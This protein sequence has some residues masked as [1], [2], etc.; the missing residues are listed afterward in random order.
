MTT[1]E[2]GCFCGQVRYPIT[3]APKASVICHCALCRRAAATPAMPWITCDAEA[4]ALTR[5]EPRTYRSSPPVTRG[6]CGACGTPLTYANDSRPGEI[7]VTTVSL[8][9]S[10][11]FAPTCH[12]RLVEALGWVKFGDGLPAYQGWKSEG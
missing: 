12:I 1:I 4:F 2:G 9:D 7:D 6:F 10:E 8:D 11:A 3:A 5:G